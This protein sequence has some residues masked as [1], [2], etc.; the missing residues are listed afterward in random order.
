MAITKHMNLQELITGAVEWP[1]IINDFI[2]KSEAGSPTLK[3]NAGA[4]LTK[5]DPFYIHTDGKAYKGTSSTFC[6]GIWQSAST[7]I[8]VDGFGQIHGIISL[9]TWTW[10][11][12]SYLYVTAGGGLTHSAPSTN[13]RAVGFAISATEVVIINPLIFGVLPVADGGTGLS[14]LGTP[15]QI[16]GVNASGTALEYKDIPGYNEEQLLAHNQITKNPGATTVT[17]IG[18]AAAPTLTA[19]T[20]SVDDASGPLLNHAT[21]TTSGNASGVISAYT[22][23]RRDWIPTYETIIRTGAAITSIRLWIGLFSASPDASS[24]P[25]IHI[26]AFRY[27]TD[28]DGTAFWR[29][30]TKDGTTINAVESSVA[31]AADTVYRLRIRVNTAGEVLFFINGTLIATH[32]TQLPGATTLLGYGNRVTTLTNASRAIKWEA[33]WMKF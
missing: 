12:G 21:S 20:S 26:A 9:G 13:A 4:A 8:G 30:V 31:I 6:H 32:T 1:A 27:A 22:I 10:T 15:N 2:N 5:G 29:T 25:A 11:T 23:C 3:A 7:G 18:F 16:F 33:I 24:D 19:T 14:V 28:A 17:T